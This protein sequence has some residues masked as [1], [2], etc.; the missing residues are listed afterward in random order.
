MTGYEQMYLA[1]VVVAFAA[2]MATLAIQQLRNAI[3]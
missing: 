3:K 2:F 1:M